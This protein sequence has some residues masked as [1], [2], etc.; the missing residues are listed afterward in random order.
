[1]EGEK[2][3][4][5]NGNKEKEVKEET[6]NCENLPGFFEFK[7]PH[8]LVNFGTYDYINDIQKKK[9][10][11]DDIVISENKGIK[12]S[13]FF[14]K[15]NENNENCFK[16]KIIGMDFPFRAKT[17]DNVM[18]EFSRIINGEEEY[19]SVP[20]KDF[21]DDSKKS[22]QKYNLYLTKS[23][24]ENFTNRIT[25]IKKEQK[26]RAGLTPEQRKEEDENSKKINTMLGNMILKTGGKKRTKR[27]TQRRNKKTTKR[28]ANKKTKM[29]KRKT[30]KRKTNK[31]RKR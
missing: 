29:K 23:L 12:N 30:H 22:F 17:I 13:P 15:K 9:N 24:H 4:T 7:T 2:E 26:R 5:L 28:K 19:Y 10:K 6:L 27:R 21:N 8:S 31:R 16:A 1:M 25:N 14:K 18:I 3:E 11:N 20:L